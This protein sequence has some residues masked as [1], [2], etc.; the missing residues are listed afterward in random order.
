MSGPRDA[1]GV[2]GRHASIEFSNSRGPTLRTPGGEKES[3]LP[4]S[5]GRAILDKQGKTG[6]K[7]PPKAGLKIACGGVGP[8][9]TV[10]TER[11]SGLVLSHLGREN[12]FA[13]L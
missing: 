1:T 12:N 6:K 13:G 7:R 5:G 10:K 3:A 9:S 11:A 8:D 4:R 2:P